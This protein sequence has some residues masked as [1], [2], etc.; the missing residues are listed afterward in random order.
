MSVMSI[1]EKPLPPTCELEL[2]RLIAGVP[3]SELSLL[4]ATDP[5]FSTGG[6]RLDSKPAVIRARLLQIVNSSQP[7]SDS[8]RRTLARR[9]QT[10]AITTLLSTELLVE[11]RHALVTLLGTPLFLIALL[12]DE[13]PDVREKGVSWLADTESFLPLSPEDALK[14]LQ[15]RFG[16]LTT[17]LGSELISGQPAT[18]QAWRAQKDRL[19]DRLRQLQTENRRL[20]GVDDRLARIT[21]KLATCETELT[22]AREKIRSAATLLK[23]RQIELETI[24]SEL[25]REQTQRD[26]RLR[27]ALELA[28]ATEFHGWLAQACALEQCVEKQSQVHEDLLIQAESAL[29]KQQERDRHSGN[30]ALLRV[31]LEHLTAAY[32]RVRQALCEALH[33]TPELK[34]LE[35]LLGHEIES[36]KHLLDPTPA[37]TPLEDALLIRIHNAEENDLP[38]VCE[39]PQQLADLHILDAPALDRLQ[40]AFQKRLMATHATVLPPDPRMQVRNPSVA[41]LSRAL[42]GQCP[43]ILLIDGHNLLF[44]LPTRYNPTRGR[45]RTEAEKRD[46]LTADIVRLISPMP[47]IRVWIIFDGP[48]RSDTQAAPNVRVTYSGGEGEHRADKVLLDNVRFFKSSA[49]DLAVILVSND[50]DLCLAARRLGACDLPVLEFGAFFHPID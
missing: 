46:L 45:S 20:K 18:Q 31:R 27:A 19:E 26:E 41:L 23:Q 48:T 9:S 33:Q 17:L 44:G 43:A 35:P 37:V 7:L 24:Q 21:T 50:R 3:D 16:G 1:C 40:L 28:L 15:E 10:A 2:Q 32:T 39:L 4:V 12:L 49:P 25:K 8:L 13:R 29:K 42:C 22:D 14:H 30:R 11:M 38:R 5:A 36:L 34:R 47:S 6:F